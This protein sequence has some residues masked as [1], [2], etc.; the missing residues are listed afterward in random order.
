VSLQTWQSGQRLQAGN[1]V[2]SRDPRDSTF[3]R[4]VLRLQEHMK[5]RTAGSETALRMGGALHLKVRTY[6]AG[7]LVQAVAG[8]LNWGFRIIPPYRTFK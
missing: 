5:F 4:Q 7:R 2:I 8:V 3:Q 6:F 1:P